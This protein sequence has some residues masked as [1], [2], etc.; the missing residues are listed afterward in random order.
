VFLFTVHQLASDSERFFPVNASNKFERAIF[1]F[2]LKIQ[3]GSRHFIKKER[4]RKNKK[5]V[6]TQDLLN[7]KLCAC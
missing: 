1:N 6:F 5:I 7:N 2:S 3:N 4:R